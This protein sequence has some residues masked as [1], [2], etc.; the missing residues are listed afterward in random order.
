MFNFIRKFTVFQKN[1]FVLA[2]RSSENIKKKLYLNSEFFSRYPKGN[3]QVDDFKGVK[4][5]F[6]GM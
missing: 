6:R 1:Q 5:R 2:V 3:F 4:L